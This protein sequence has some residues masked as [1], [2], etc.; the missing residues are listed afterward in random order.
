M[1]TAEEAAGQG[2]TAAAAST[3]R[4]RADDN[5]NVREL[6]L[7]LVCYGG[8]SLAIYMHGMTKELQKLVV[9]S[10]ACERDQAHNPFPERTVERAYWEALRSAWE[11]SADN[12]RDRVVTRVVIDVVAGTSAGGINGVILC[13]ALAHNRSQDALRDL[14]FDRADFKQL[15]GGSW[16]RR[17][18]K[19]LGF[20]A[21]RAALGAMDTSPAPWRPGG[22]EAPPSLMP[23]GH[24]LQLFV[25][26]T[27]YY[28]YHNSMLIEDPATVGERRNRH[29]LRFRYEGAANGKV[30]V[31]QFDKPH[32]GA[33]AFAARSTSSFPG[34]FPPVDLKMVQD[35]VGDLER[36]KDEF[37]AAYELADADAEKTYFVDGGVL[38]NYPFQPAI[39]AI[40]KARSEAE[41]DRYLLY[42][43][44][45]PGTPVQNPDGARPTLFGAI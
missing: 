16:P 24:P 1:H 10:R 38:N 8:V 11:S 34:A 7:G 5:A 29:L 15:L 32:N 21:R 3:A 43:Q 4:Q 14:W 18:I 27:D 2:S 12:E 17:W 19:I 45:D 23:A 22:D 33:L 30:V 41:V 40:F 35:H 44:P 20:V 31:D 13:K 42:L 36:F 25:T 6:R 26:T 9:A 39:D 37:F 28:G